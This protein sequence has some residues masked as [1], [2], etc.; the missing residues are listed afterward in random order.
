MQG[1]G[2]ASEKL[3]TDIDFQKRSEPVVLLHI[4]PTKIL[5]TCSKKAI[6]E[7]KGY[8]FQGVRPHSAEQALIC[9]PFQIKVGA[10]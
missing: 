6:V 3:E 7:M 5:A 10:F 8:V 4:R 9:K 1:L 2:L